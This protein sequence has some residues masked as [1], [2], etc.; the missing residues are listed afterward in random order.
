MTILISCSWGASLA[1]AYLIGLR[2]GDDRAV[3]RL[4]TRY[5]LHIHSVH[6]AW[7]DDVE[8]LERARRTTSPN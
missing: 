4:A 5:L 7:H 2:R 6:E 8:A 1:A 3:E